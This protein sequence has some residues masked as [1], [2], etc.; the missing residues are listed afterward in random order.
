MALGK[1]LFFRRK[2]YMK[3]I[4]RLPQVVLSPVYRQYISGTGTKKP[5]QRRIILRHIANKKEGIGAIDESSRIV[6][7][8]FIMVPASTVCVIASL[9]PLNQFLHTFRGYI[10]RKNRNRQRILIFIPC[11]GFLLHEPKSELM[12]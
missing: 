9:A 6:G 2:S 12:V 8:R 10:A 5:E 1:L 4:Q 7:K 3:L 11:K